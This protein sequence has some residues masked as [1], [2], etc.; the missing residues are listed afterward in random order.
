[1]LEPL[2]KEKGLYELFERVEVPLI[3]ILAKIE[4]NGVCVDTEVFDR[5]SENLGKQIEKLTKEIY[6]LA[7]QEFNI[8][9]TQQL[10]K[11][12]FEGMKL[13]VVKKTKTGYSTDVAVLEK[14]AVEHELPRKI[15]DYRTLTK[16]KSTYIDA[17][18]TLINP[19]TGRIHTSLNQTVTA[20]GR[21]SSSEPNLQ[22]IPIRSE[23]GREI[24]RAFIP[25]AKNKVLMSADYSQIELRIL[26]HLSGDE[27]LCSAF[28]DGTD[29]HD[30]T[31]A[32]IFGVPIED[33]T[34]DM[35][36]KA[37]VAN[38]GILYGISASKLAADI[39][40]KQE[41]AQH[42]IGHYF[43]V[44]PRIKEYIDST[45]EE[46][47]RNG[48][49]ATIM[50]RRRYI[51]DIKSANIGVRRFAERTAINTP[52]QGSAADLIKLAMIEIDKRIDQLGC[53][54]IMILQVHDELI[55]ETRSNEA[56]TI[57]PIIKEMMETAY[58]MNVPIVTDVR[59]GQNWL[60]AHD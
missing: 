22:N 7:G 6:S 43:E 2:L 18:P 21:L 29:I 35:R 36:R 33:V 9:S 31:S 13:P 4:L 48:Y 28:R 54:C 27:V 19:A 15:L 26:A 56:A 8:N 32:K 60:E 55:F 50:K 49:V 44:F 11:I 52:I 39:G 34:G 10:G 12:L 58:P 1:V 5:L 51:P 24:R 30:Q 46:A 38:Y 20:T 3:R 45:L 59:V 23:V 40:I 41:E 53:D 14:L 16:L 17:L 57:A 37:K 42:F 25:S 47:R